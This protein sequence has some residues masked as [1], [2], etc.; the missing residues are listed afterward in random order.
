MKNIVNLVTQTLAIENRRRQEE[1]APGRW[2]RGNE[3]YL[4]SN[5]SPLDMS[6]TP[7]MQVDVP[8]VLRII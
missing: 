1:G 3:I 2:G 7:A 8:S 5:L 6:T 4:D